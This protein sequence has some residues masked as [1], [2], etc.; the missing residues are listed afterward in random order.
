MRSLTGYTVSAAVAALVAS[1]A[2]ADGAKPFDAA[3][4]FGVRPTV[5]GVRLSPDGASV[6]FF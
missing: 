1:V 4:A 6:G 5:M 3:A 2:L